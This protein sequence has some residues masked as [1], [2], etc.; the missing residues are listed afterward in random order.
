MELLEAAE[1]GEAD[2]DALIMERDA[3]VAA[4]ALFGPVAGARDVWRLHTIL[5]APRIAAHDV[6]ST[7]VDAV[8]QRARA[9]GAR[10]LVA[11]LPADPG[12]GDSLPLLRASDFAQEGRITDFYRDGVA[13]L[14]L[15]RDL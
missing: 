6:G 15:R 13:L 8:V 4:L 11:E 5:L 7:I 10:M 2:S 3:T 12:Y 14:F 1:R 9:R